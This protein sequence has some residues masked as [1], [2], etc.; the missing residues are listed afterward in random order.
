MPRREVKQAEFL[1]MLVFG[2]II[3]CIICVAY[4]LFFTTLLPFQDSPLTLL[5]SF[6]HRCIRHRNFDSETVRLLSNFLQHCQRKYSADA[7]NMTWQLS[8]ETLQKIAVS[9]VKIAISQS[10][11]SAFHQREFLRCLAV[12]QFEKNCSGKS[13]F[14]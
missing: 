2:I 13:Y 3:N 4:V 12:A 9:L 14:E 11:D 7:A 10:F 8:K 5:T 1:Y 6:L